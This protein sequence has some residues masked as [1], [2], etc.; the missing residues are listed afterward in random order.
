M[1]EG[2][3]QKMASQN[4]FDRAIS[5]AQ[6]AYSRVMQTSQ[7]LLHSLHGATSNLQ[8]KETVAEPEL[9]KKLPKFPKKVQIKGYN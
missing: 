5:E 4:E 3:A 1:N 7:A 2:I 8:E 9:S 6:T